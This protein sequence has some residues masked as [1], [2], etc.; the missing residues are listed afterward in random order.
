MDGAPPP[1]PLKVLV[2]ASRMT[3]KHALRLYVLECHPKNLVQVC[4]RH[5][6]PIAYRN[7]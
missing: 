1:F 4:T 6:Q 5:D 7:K 2:Q 3:Q